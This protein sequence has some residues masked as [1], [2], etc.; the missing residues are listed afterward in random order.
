MRE[1]LSGIVAFVQAVETGSFAQAAERMQLTR[2]AVGK[3]HGAGWRSG[4]ASVYSTVLHA[5]RA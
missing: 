3:K 4:S 1:R 2:S 5:A